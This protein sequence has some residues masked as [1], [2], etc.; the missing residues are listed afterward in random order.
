MGSAKQINLMTAVDESGNNPFHHA[1]RS[2]TTDVMAFFN[3]QTKGMLT[4]EK[5][6]VDATNNAGETALL[7]G[8]YDRNKRYAYLTIYI[9]MKLT[10]WTDCYCNL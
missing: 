5:R 6:L 4:P 7:R 8:R 2:Q 1:V 10:D 3:Q 9:S